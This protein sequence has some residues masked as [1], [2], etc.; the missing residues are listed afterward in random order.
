[1]SNRDEHAEV[2]EM[3][4]TYMYLLVVVVI[5]ISVASAS[6]IFIGCSS[7]KKPTK[8]G[9]VLPL[10][11]DAAA[12]GQS[13]QRAINLA[14]QNYNALHT[15]DGKSITPVFEDSRA[16]P[17]AGVA[18]ARKLI[19]SDRVPII[20]GG[21]ASS[22]TLAIAPIANQDSVV[23]LSPASSAPS[24]TKAGEYVFRVCASDDIEGRQL[25]EF[26]I[27]HFKGHEA[28]IAYINNDYGVGIK[29]VF[30]EIYA[31]SGGK[32]V[33]TESFEQGSTD[34]RSLL[35]KIKSNDPD[36]LVIVG[37]KEL[38]QLLKQAHELD[39]NCQVL[40]TVMFEDPSIIKVAGVAADRV[41]YSTRSYDPTSDDKATAT[42]VAEYKAK[43]GA[44][45]DIYAALAFDAANLVV[46]A[47]KSGA[48]S[49]T[50]IMQYLLTVKGRPGASGEIT[51]DANGDV[52]GQAR[53][54]TVRNGKFVDMDATN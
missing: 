47:L 41:I 48:I 37:Y 40:S 10:T 4:C 22:V 39:I 49:G 25:A 38:G 1:M 32:V 21:M 17:A 53:F 44:T 23:L 27:N 30:S 16:E 11:G 6:F 43:Y 29:D 20:V 19:T 18:A 5:A 31:D 13:A 46:D 14:F 15:S 54:K 8:V 42:F 7:E 26:A 33:A 36:V 34:F 24:I 12:Y 51:F 9:V 35:A 28:A 2:D 45:P 3:R 50:D 52:I